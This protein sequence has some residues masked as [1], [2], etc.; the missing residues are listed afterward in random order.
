MQSGRATYLLTELANFF[1]A[2]ALPYI[3]EGEVEGDKNF[4]GA[5][6]NSTYRVEGTDCPCRCCCRRVKALKTGHQSKEEA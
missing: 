4:A 2:N 1:N 6:T 5:V 3:V